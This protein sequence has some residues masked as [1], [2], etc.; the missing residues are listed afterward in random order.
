MMPQIRPNKPL[1]R[2]LGAVSLWTMPAAALAISCSVQ[3]L[4]ASFGVYSPQSA[5]PATATGAIDITCTCQVLV[6]CTAF[7][8]RVDITAGQSGS[9]AARQMK[10]ATGSLGYNLYQDP[11]YTTIWGSDSAGRSSLYLLTLFGSYQRIPVYARAPAGQTVR[12]G[13]YVDTPIITIIY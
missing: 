9:T 3:T 13:N 12:P 4:P 2:L 8:Y 5:T 10:A 7:T 1:V 11:G 6:D